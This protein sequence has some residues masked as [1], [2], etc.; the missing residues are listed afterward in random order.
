MGS[1]GTVFIGAFVLLV[2][3]AAVYLALLRRSVFILAYHSIGP[4]QTNVPGLVIETRDFIRHLRLISLLRFP[5]KALD[6]IAREAA[7]GKRPRFPV[8]CITFDDGYRTVLKN[9]APVLKALNWPATLFVPTAY[10]GGV[11]EWDRPHGV[12]EMPLMNWDELRALESLGFQIGSHG[13]HHRSLIRLSDEEWQDE[14]EGSLADLGQNVPRHSR[15]FCYPFGHR[16]PGIRAYLEKA[17]YEGACSLVHD[18]FITN[19]F[20]MGRLLVPSGSLMR[21]AIAFALYPVLSVAR[22]MRTR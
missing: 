6:D 21:F 4:G 13:R 11:N 22:N 10:V 20:D 2:V 1:A 8:V 9:A 14:L 18:A 5:V 3:L 16:A 19:R 12:A 17:G 15:I 7:S